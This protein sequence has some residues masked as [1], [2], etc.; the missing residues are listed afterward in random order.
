MF[1]L[2]VC[3]WW[4]WC[5]WLLFACLC[6]LFGCLFVSLKLF[7]YFV[8]CWCLCCLHCLFCFVLFCFCIWIRM[9]RS[10]DWSDNFEERKTPIESSLHPEIENQ[11]GNPY[12]THPAPQIRKHDPDIPVTWDKIHYAGL[13]EKNIMNLISMIADSTIP[14]SLYRWF[15]HIHPSNL[16]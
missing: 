14:S 11:Y 10:F 7:V 9:R 1:V 16:Q 3:W 12:R 6:C 13:C 4:S 2:F 15:L 8:C 5:C